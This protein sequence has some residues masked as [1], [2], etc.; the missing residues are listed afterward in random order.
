MPSEPGDCLRAC[1]RGVADYGAYPLVQLALDGAD[2]P[3]LAVT[4]SPESGR[5]SPAP[6]DVLVVRVPVRGPRA[7]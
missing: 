5:R 7:W 6:D 3:A 4:C 1:V 2:G